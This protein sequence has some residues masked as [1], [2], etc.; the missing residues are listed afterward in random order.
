[1]PPSTHLTVPCTFNLASIQITPT[2]HTMQYTSN[3]LLGRLLLEWLLRYTLYRILSSMLT[4]RNDSARD[5]HRTRKPMRECQGGNSSFF[6]LLFHRRLRHS[7]RRT[8]VLHNISTVRRYRISS[9]NE[10]APSNVKQRSR[11]SLAPRSRVTLDFV[12]I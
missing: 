3:R 8:H 7:P 2:T 11:R 6:P 9:T 10:T 5:I 4:L 12:R 1:M